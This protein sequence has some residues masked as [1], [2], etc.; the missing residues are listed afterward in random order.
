MAILNKNNFEDPAKADPELEKKLK[1]NRKIAEA[2]VTAV[3][4]Y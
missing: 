1:E 2:R 3:I 4:F